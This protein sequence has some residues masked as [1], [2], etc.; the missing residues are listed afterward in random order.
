MGADAITQTSSTAVLRR[1]FAILE[2]YRAGG[3]PVEVYKA[4]RLDDPDELRALTVVAPDEAGGLEALPRVFAALSTIQSPHLPKV[5]DYGWLAGAEFLP[6]DKHPTPPAGARFYFAR[7]WADGTILGNLLDNDPADGR[8]LVTTLER[9]WQVASGVAALHAVGVVHLDLSPATVLLP[10]G[11]GPLMLV[12]LG[13]CW[14][15]Q[16]PFPGLGHRGTPGYTAPETFAGGAEGYELSMAADIFS[17]GVLLFEMVSGRTP[18]GVGID[19]LRYWSELT[20]RAKPF[21]LPMQCDGNWGDGML[22][23]HLRWSLE[24]MARRRPQTV[25]EFLAPIG[26]LLRALKA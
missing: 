16:D 5:T 23:A 7:Q 11:G 24:G 12:G 14:R 15:L 4:A 17:L 2:T 18:F 3:G 20:R 26:L 21:R 6:V 25:A 22:N 10:A 19:Y 1:R 13:S 8:S 9:I